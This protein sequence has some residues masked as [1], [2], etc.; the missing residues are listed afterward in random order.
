MVDLQMRVMHSAASNRRAQRQKLTG[1][2]GGV[3]EGETLVPGAAG[4]DNHRR[5]GTRRKYEALL[6]LQTRADRLVAQRDYL[7]DLHEN[8]LRRRG[9]RL[10]RFGKLQDHLAQPASLASVR[11]TAKENFDSL[12][13]HGTSKLFLSVD[14][15]DALD[16]VLSGEEGGEGDDDGFD[17]SG[18]PTWKLPRSPQ[19]LKAARWRHRKTSSLASARHSDMWW[20]AHVTEDVGGTP[21]DIREVV[22]P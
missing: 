16:D 4:L 20:C 15:S 6:A 5:W 18:K 17:P 8:A 14:S 9:R 13:D 7:S 3:V 10:E 2:E 21:A 12:S 22:S 11:G 19:A 1:A